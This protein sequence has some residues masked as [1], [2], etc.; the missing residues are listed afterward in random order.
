[1]PL[2]GLCRG[3]YLGVVLKHLIALHVVTL[4]HDDRAVEAR[5]VQAEVV[6]PDFFVCRVGEN[7]VGKKTAHQRGQKEKHEGDE[8]REISSYYCHHLF[9][10]F[11]R[12]NSPKSFFIY[13]FDFARL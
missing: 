8:T 9:A 7:L 10:L 12:R 2:D 11:M 4:E 3:S 6:G 5:H 1:M 13:F